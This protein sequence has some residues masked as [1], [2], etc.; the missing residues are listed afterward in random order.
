M[1]ICYQCEE[2]IAPQIPRLG[3]RTDHWKAE[4]WE[5]A[6]DC[7]ADKRDQHDGPEWEWLVDKMMKDDLRC[8]PPK[9][10]GHRQT[11][12]DESVVA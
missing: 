6:E 3:R 4:P 2:E 5:I 7:A 8:Q 10:E 11:E 1:H 12:E 9:D